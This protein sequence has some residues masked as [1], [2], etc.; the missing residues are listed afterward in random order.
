MNTPILHLPTFAHH[1]FGVIAPNIYWKLKYLITSKIYFVFY[2]VVGLFFF[3][4]I[5]INLSWANMN[6]TEKNYPTI[7]HWHPFSQQWEKIKIN[8]MLV[9]ACA[10]LYSISI[11][12]LVNLPF[13]CAKY[14]WEHP[15]PSQ[16]RWLSIFYGHFVL[17]SL[18]VA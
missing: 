11:F 18:W 4:F 3:S 6:V 16:Q 14:I 12:I 9:C 8:K 13:F 15:K 5:H 2:L 1:K 7:K 10:P 17:R